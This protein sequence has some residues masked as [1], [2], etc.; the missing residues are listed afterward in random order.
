MTEANKIQK[1][2]AE[3]YHASI[4]K[5]SQG[6]TITLDVPA[7]DP[8]FMQAEEIATN[9][10]NN[11]TQTAPENPVAESR[12]GKIDNDAGTPAPAPPAT[13]ALTPKPQTVEIIHIVV[14]GDT[15][16]TIAKHYVKNPYRYPELARLS[17]IKNPDLI[18]PGDRVR[19]IKHK[20]QPRANH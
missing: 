15:L 7:D 10:Y 18:Y 17:K 11:K 14:K 1:P 13:P 16:W 9:E 6:L 5:D 4:E 8:S 12:P 20:H 19:I 3:E 2:A